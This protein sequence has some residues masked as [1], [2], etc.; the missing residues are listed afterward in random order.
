MHFRS[1]HHRFACVVAA[2]ILTLMGLAVPSAH[3]QDTSSSAAAILDEAAS[4][5]LE[6]ESFHFSVST[7][8][9]KTE[10]SDQIE[11]S[12][13]E[14]D[15]LRPDAFQAEFTV[16]LGFVSLKLN[17]IGIGASLWVSDPTAGN[18]QYIELSADGEETLP[19][20]LLLNPDQLVMQA[21][22]L[23]RD[24][25]IKGD[26]EIEDVPVVNIEGTFDPED[27]AQFG[28]PAPGTLFSGV[29]PLTVNLWI[30]KEHRIVRAEFAG[31]LLP[32]ELDAGPLVR[33]VDLSAFNEP[34]TIE[35]PAGQG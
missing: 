9:G 3:A 5:M 29:E 11:L 22:S 18:D 8:L 14:G 24:P 2:C 7:P 26:D 28:T 16:E 13:I 17:V 19:P 12:G 21:V 20:Q 30:D 32:S 33:R 10:L 15:V 25:V 6:L 31:A 23:L 1:G 27:L 34:V 35:A 4:K